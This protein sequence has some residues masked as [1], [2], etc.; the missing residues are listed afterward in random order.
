MRSP[1]FADGFI[2]G[3]HIATPRRLQQWVDVR[4]SPPSPPVTPLQPLPLLD[5]E[6]RYPS[7]KRRSEIFGSTR[8]NRSSLEIRGKRTTDEELARLPRFTPWKFT[9]A[10]LSCTCIFSSKVGQIS[11]RFWKETW[12]RGCSREGDE[13]RKGKERERGGGQELEGGGEPLGRRQR[14]REGEDRKLDY[15]RDRYGAAS[16]WPV[17]HHHYLPPLSHDHQVRHGH[18]LHHQV[19]RR[20]GRRHQR[21]YNQHG[22]FH[23]PWW[24]L[25]KFC[26]HRQFMRSPSLSLRSGH[27]LC[28]PLYRHYSQRP[29]HH[30]P[31]LHIVATHIKLDSPL[32]STVGIHQAQS[33]RLKIFC[34][35]TPWVMKGL[36][37][38]LAKFSIPLSCP[39]SSPQVLE[40]IRVTG[41][42]PKGFRHY[43]R[44]Q[45]GS[46]SPMASPK[47]EVNE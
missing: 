21:S 32:P 14:E 7:R 40:F 22:R 47:Q 15:S 24:Y 34:L 45:H 6:F 9:Q 23:A 12:M 8:N 13:G 19:G 29:L 16:L 35:K 46:P 30:E 4:D 20:G 25:H 2:L 18:H 11:L 27:L 3:L 39:I 33:P 1:L 43:D 5:P 36:S 42:V 38:K 17:D 28:L 26:R 44:M 31:P 10:F 41:M 37:F